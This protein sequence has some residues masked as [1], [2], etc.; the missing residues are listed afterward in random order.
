MRRE[1]DRRTH[2]CVRICISRVCWTHGDERNVEVE[3][4]QLFCSRVF[5]AKKCTYVGLKRKDLGGALREG[6]GIW[7]KPARFRKT[8]MH[9]RFWHHCFLPYSFPPPTQYEEYV[10]CTTCR[11]SVVWMNCLAW[12]IVFTVHDCLPGET[13]CTHNDTTLD[14]LSRRSKRWW[15]SRRCC[16]TQ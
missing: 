1:E 3:E 10:L 4:R 8:R 5:Q 11:Y 9:A 14:A 2:Q 6:G 7:K 13:Y 15:L 12:S 16:C